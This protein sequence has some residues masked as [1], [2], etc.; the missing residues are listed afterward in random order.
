MTNENDVTVETFEVEPISEEKI[1]EFHSRS[2]DDFRNFIKRPDEYFA[3]VA[4]LQFNPNRTGC[5]LPWNFAGPVQDF[6]FRP[7]EL[8]VWA[9]A[10]GTGKSLLTSQIAIELSAQGEPCCLA[11]FEMS[12]AMTSFRLMK[13]V[14]GS[15]SDTD[16][17]RNALYALRGRIYLFDQQRRVTY[18]EMYKLAYYCAKK[19][20]VKHL[21]IDSLMM[22]VDGT[23]DYNGQKDF[24]YQLTQIAQHLEIHIHLIAHMRKGSINARSGEEQD[25]IAGTGAITDLAFN[26]FT[27]IQ[28]R[29]KK[30]ARLI[31]DED[32]LRELQNEY[33]IL[34]KLTKHRNGQMLGAIP[35]W[36]CPEYLSYCDSPD[37][38]PPSLYRPDLVSDEVIDF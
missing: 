6:R 32:K 19:L 23:D 8:T 36:Y 13:Q 18:D 28:N 14:I 30:A 26:V 37:R 3:Q 9:G 2:N 22:C 31:N 17:L 16:E 11:S 27:V 25:N 33:D 34:L 4:D 24:V 7:A 29:E 20:K 38:I 12:G 15:P 10:N 1:N 21:F 35:L 5:K